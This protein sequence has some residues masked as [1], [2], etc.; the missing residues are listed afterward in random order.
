MGDNPQNVDGDVMVEVPNMFD[1]VENI[2]F[3]RCKSGES[4]GDLERKLV[5]HILVIAHISEHA[6]WLTKTMLLS[7][8]RPKVEAVA[9]WINT[10]RRTQMKALAVWLLRLLQCEILM[11][12]NVLV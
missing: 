1:V 10:R 4:G 8:R 7:T 5:R 9:V 6:T 3:L 11:Q 2:F 12:N